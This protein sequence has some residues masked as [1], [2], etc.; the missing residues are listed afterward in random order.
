MPPTF[1]KGRRDTKLA[2]AR[3]ARAA[4]VTFLEGGDSA[5]LFRGAAR[6]ATLL[7][8]IRADIA[9]EGRVRT[10]EAVQHAK[11]GNTFAKRR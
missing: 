6:N 10:D 8:F 4:V 1:K 7:P 3:G 9:R 2:K 5:R 11:L